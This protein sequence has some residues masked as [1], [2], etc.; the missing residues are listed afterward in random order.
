[1]LRS[2]A[3]REVL[4]FIEENNGNASNCDDFFLY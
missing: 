4:G 2:G 1:M 3:K